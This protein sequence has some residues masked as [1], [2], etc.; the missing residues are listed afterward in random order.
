M[1][2]TLS[3]IVGASAP[4]R[5]S[6]HASQEARRGHSV[7]PSAEIFKR[8][9]YFELKEKSLFHRTSVG[10]QL[11]WVH[12]RTLV[13]VGATAALEELVVE[14]I[15][16][17]EGHVK[18]PGSKS[19]S[20]RVLLLAALSEGT[21][22]VENIL[23]RM[24]IHVCFFCNGSNM[25]P[26]VRLKVFLLFKRSQRVD[27]ILLEWREETPVLWLLWRRVDISIVCS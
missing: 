5:N 25:R 19:L 23:V 13:A 1:Q 12:N 6:S 3:R 14:P 27:V 16:V 21:T 17:I 11:Q 22:V 15:C 10:P 9:S 26:C 20:N 2:H 4:C 8:R 7:F 24:V 18:L